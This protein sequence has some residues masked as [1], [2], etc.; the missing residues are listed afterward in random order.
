MKL[1]KFLI[2]FILCWQIC[3][4]QTLKHHC[5]V[6]YYDAALKESDSV[7]WD[8]TPVMVSCG[9]VTR[10]NPFKTDPLLPHSASPNDYAVNSADAKNKLYNADRPSW[11]DEGHLMSYQDAMCDPFGIFE[12]FYMTNMLPQVHAFNAGDWKTLEVQERVWAKTATLHILA[13]GIGINTG[14]KNFPTG[15]LPSGE[16][17]PAFMWKAI[18]MNGKW[19]AWIMPNQVTSVGH[20]YDYWETTTGALDQATGLKL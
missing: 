3:P 19:T 7:S 16:K 13:G 6:A 17:I 5:Y 20:P 11:I 1:F 18:Y 15:H 2:L 10:K 12:C 9:D 4:A 14:L 8:L